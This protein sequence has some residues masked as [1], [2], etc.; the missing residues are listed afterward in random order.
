MCIHIK[1]ARGIIAAWWFIRVE[2]MRKI[3][4]NYYVL[5]RRRINKQIV[6]GNCNNKCGVSFSYL[7][8]FKYLHAFQRSARL[9][10]RRYKIVW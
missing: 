6:Y 4:E 3:L 5:R 10:R 1:S 9:R 7:L 2:N 8:L